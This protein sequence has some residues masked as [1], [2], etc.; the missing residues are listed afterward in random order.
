MSSSHLPRSLAILVIALAAAAIAPSAFSQVAVYRFNFEKEGPS[1]NY[2]FYEEAWVVADAVGGPASWLL[3]FREG[4][5]RRYV[6]VTDFGSLFFPNEGKNYIGVISAS[7][8]SGTPQTTF[9][10]IGE[11]ETELKGG[12]VKVKVPKAMKGYA[13][14][15]DDESSV[16]F[17]DDE[18]N[19]GYAG[20]S[21]MSGSLE[22]TRSKDASSRNLTAQ[23]TFDELI[24]YLERRGYSEFEISI[25]PTDT[26][27]SA[28]NTTN[29]S[30]SAFNLSDYVLTTPT[31][32]TTN[33]SV[34]TAGS[35]GSTG[36]LVIYSSPSSLSSMRSLSSTDLLD[37]LLQT[38]GASQ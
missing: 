37:Y 29:T 15:A 14:S 35:S 23:E 4:P 25:T 38:S 36:S 24:Q 9:L 5:H 3:T 1:I 11:M 34:F 22:V 20:I 16:P 8:A 17:D 31:T 19:V 32:T 18:G 28:S 13:L 6:A 26:A 30:D 21:Q 10:A 27:T 2:G 33:T 7:A 12:N